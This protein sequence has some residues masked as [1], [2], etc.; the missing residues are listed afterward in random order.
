MPRLLH[1]WPSIVLMLFMCG[2]GLSDRQ[3][4]ERTRA[5][6]NKT[7]AELAALQD[8]VAKLDQDAAAKGYLD[9]LE[10]LDTLTTKGV[11]TPEEFERQKRAILERQQSSVVAKPVP[12]AS[13]MDELAK[14]IRDLQ[15]LY[16][17]NA[18]NLP[19]RDAKK[20]QLIKRPLQST[21]MKKDLETVQALYNE[22]AIT[23][24]E[25]DTLR[26]KLLELDTGTK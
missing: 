5:E 22:S 11:L 2:C 18:I 7:H 26:Q 3:E 12:P 19:D 17:N 15:S 14:Q 9:E 6:L 8:R 25:R 23:L 21:D 24:P 13:G 4:L 1:V 20:T 10:K 16:S